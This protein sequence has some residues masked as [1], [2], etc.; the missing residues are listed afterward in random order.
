MRAFHL[1]Q[2]AAVGAGLCLAAAAQ[3]LGVG[4]AAPKLTVKTFLKG[5]P[6]KAF[7]RDTTYVVDFW[8]TWVSPCRKT[9][10]HLSEV[11]KRY[12]DQRVRVLGVSVWE[13]MPGDVAPYV[14]AFG[15]QMAY[16]VAID[17]VLP[18][19]KPWH[20][21]MALTWLRAAGESSLPTAFIVDGSGRIAW[22]GDSAAL[23]KPLEQ[24]VAGTWDLEAA[25]KAHE[26]RAKVNK[27]SLKLSELFKAHDYAGALLVVDELIKAAPERE[28]RTGAWRFCCL[29]NL[30]REDEGY[31]YAKRLVDS[32]LKDEALEL[33]LI[34]W[35]IVDPGVER[36]PRRD[37]DF[38]LRVAQRAV[39][40]SEQKNGAILDT[41]ALVY[42][43][44]GD[45]AKA[46]ELE[47]RA[48]ELCKGTEWLEEVS[49]R[50]EQFKKA[51]SFAP[52]PD[53]NRR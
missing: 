23:D 3:S 8:A 31:A 10:P 38:A 35:F 7:E 42:F 25:K 51:R 50:L 2:R 28:Q 40:L 45:I 6:L 48:V 5:E 1:L 22:I 47:E 16:T 9:I 33:N 44:R 49:A 27:L 21:S 46:I 13:D 15:E 11:Q 30:G 52:Q 32:V 18:D 24:I 41:L 34:A 26:S 4:D 29:L 17:T 36:V 37:L 53:Q 14:A 20:G 19:A 39:D 43:T 12:A